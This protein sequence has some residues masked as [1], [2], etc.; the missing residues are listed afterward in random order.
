MASDPFYQSRDWKNTRQ[1]VLARDN[2]LCQRCLKL[3]NRLTPANTVHHIK[4][5]KDYPE[6]ALDMDNLISWCEACHTRY[7]KAN[8]RRKTY[9]KQIERKARTIKG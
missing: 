2:Y 5:F 1:A 8:D 3:H 4:A 6:L 7:E 9:T